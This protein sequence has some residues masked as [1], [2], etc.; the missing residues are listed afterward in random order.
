MGTN[1]KFVSCIKGSFS[2]K[3]IRGPFFICK[4]TKP[5]KA[6][7]VWQKTTLFMW[8]VLETWHGCVHFLNKPW[9]ERLYVHGNSGCIYLLSPQLLSL[10]KPDLPPIWGFQ[11]TCIAK[12]KV[13]NK[14]SATGWFLAKHSKM[15]EYSK[16]V[17][18]VRN[19]FNT[20]DFELSLCW[21]SGTTFEFW[22]KAGLL[23]LGWFPF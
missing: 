18:D 5:G 2:K 7:E 16:L 10:A 14:N 22:H 11:V 19:A 1:V 6:R 17:G 21:V 13:Q 8:I 15:E 3:K 20:G 4:K 23:R 12:G 9:V